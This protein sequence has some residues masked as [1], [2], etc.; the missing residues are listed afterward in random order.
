M[1]MATNFVFPDVGEGIQE[2]EI[3]K[4]LVK[5]GDLVKAAQTIV[6]VETDKAVADLPAPVSGKILKINFKEGQTVKVGQTLC[7]IGGEK[8]KISSDKIPS[9]K[10]ISSIEKKIT[11]T[12]KIYEPVAEKKLHS[13][14][15]RGT[16]ESA[17]ILAVPAVRKLAANLG[18]DL[19]TIKGSGKGGI[20]LES[21]IQ[22]SAGKMQEKEIP[23][24]NIVVK[25]KYDDYGYLE[26]IPLKGIRKTIAQNMIRSQ[27]EAAQV[28]A[29]EDIDVSSLWGLREKEKK[30]AEKQ[31]VKLTFLPFIIKACIAALKENPILNSSLEG[32]AEQGSA[33][34]RSGDGTSDEEIIIK[35]YY[36]IGVAVETDVGLMV[37][38]VKIAESKSIISLAREIA[39]LAE[40]A[41]KRTIDL[42]DLHGSTF[43]ITNYGSIGGT[44]GTPI[45]NPGEAGILGLGRIFDRAVFDDKGKLKSVKI[46]PVSLTFDHRILDGAQAARFLESL[47]MFLEDPDHLML[48]MK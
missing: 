43:T 9:E 23:Q 15:M 46:L 11:G 30:N 12:G 10:N 38:V 1:E 48:E 32:K 40:K 5:P 21:D 47:K 45:I 18:V 25:K 36:N 31:G 35:K 4:W 16:Q 13:A 29:M 33:N 7:V 37:P 34:P 27:T 14:T 39:E 6:Q 20:I 8:D 22:K 44:Y 17:K 24:Q 2:G 26:R 19:T 41:R 28:T 3:V 42:M